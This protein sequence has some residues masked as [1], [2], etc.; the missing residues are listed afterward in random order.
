MVEV[1]V[2]SQQSLIHLLRRFGLQAK[3]V[4]APLIFNSTLY[5]V[6][7]AVSEPKTVTQGVFQGYLV[8]TYSIPSSVARYSS[9]VTMLLSGFLFIV[10]MS[11]SV[12]SKVCF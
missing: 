6:L 8:S 5:F 2:L 10:F 12:M 9:A 3:F 11:S 7:S 1:E 4:M